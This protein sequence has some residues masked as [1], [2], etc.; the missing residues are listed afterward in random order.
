MQRA[1]GGETNS[2][3]PLSS[4]TVCLIVSVSVSH[5]KQ[6]ATT[7][8]R[9][10]QG[11]KRLW[12][13]FFHRGRRMLF[14]PPFFLSSVY[15]GTALA[16][17]LFSYLTQGCRILWCGWWSSNSIFLHCSETD[18]GER[19]WGREGGRT[20]GTTDVREHLLLAVE[21]PWHDIWIDSASGWNHVRVNVWSLP[22]DA[23]CPQ[24]N[25]QEDRRLKWQ[26]LFFHFPTDHQPKTRR[27]STHIFTFIL[28]AK[29]TWAFFSSNV[30]STCK[31]V[32]THEI[33]N[34]FM[35]TSTLLCG[36][37]R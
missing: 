19:H 24:K 21:L 4:P 9:P 14:H 32:S 10:Y 34:Y 2:A 7:R 1:G 13:L 15:L 17:C 26:S 16:G 36:K 20:E 29:P 37:T 5:R 3:A 22:A 35:S 31:T 8:V 12:G 11:V 6:T 23:K 18:R 30:P 25:Q 28:T 33:Q 27:R